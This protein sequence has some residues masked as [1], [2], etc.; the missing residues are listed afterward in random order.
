M[1]GNPGLG[2]ALAFMVACGL[3]AAS[4]VSTPAAHGPRARSGGSKAH[5]GSWRVRPG[6]LRARS[7][8]APP[9]RFGL[10][11]ASSSSEAVQEGR[12]AHGR[13]TVRV[14][15]RN[16]ND[17]PVTVFGIGRS[18][19]G[20]RLLS[21][22]RPA[23]HSLGPERATS[24]DLKYRVTDCG[25]VPRG[26]WPIPVRL[27]RNGA[28]EVAYPSMRMTAG[29]STNTGTGPESWQSV[30]SNEICDIWQSH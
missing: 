22:R 6:A 18:G 20:L 1:A 13:F 26:N 8:S 11:A 29:N 7:A 12:E 27:E 14:T 19:P 30:L 21:T 4:H 28:P 24:F 3:L 5:L 16:L 23:P 17:E 2:A 25:A 9:S 10:E 15:V